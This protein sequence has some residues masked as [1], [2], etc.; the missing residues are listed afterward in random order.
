MHKPYWE[1]VK[2]IYCK[3]I[4]EI[5][6]VKIKKGFEIKKVFEFWDFYKSLQNFQQKFIDTL[7]K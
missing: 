1:E 5:K 4:W 6:L 2:K 7:E 3:L